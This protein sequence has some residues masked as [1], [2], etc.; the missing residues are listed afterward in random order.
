MTLEN[1]KTQISGLKTGAKNQLPKTDST[2]IGTSHKEVAKIWE[3]VILENP[4]HITAIIEG[5][6][7]H[8]KATWSD[9]KKT[10]RYDATIENEYMQEKFFL[11]P[12]K[13]ENGNI[14][15]QNGNTIIVT[16]GKKYFVYLSPAMVTI[17]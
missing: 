12:A 10:V 2:I 5:K 14:T 8:F 16:N 9:S 6:K 7:I 13:N 4:K 1:L 17:I 15:I 11:T 3:Q